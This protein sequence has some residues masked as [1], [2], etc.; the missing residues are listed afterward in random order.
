ML[1]LTG[2]P[3]KTGE[4][5]W[6]LI[7]RWTLRIKNGAFGYPIFAMPINET[8]RDEKGRDA[9]SHWWLALITH[10]ARAGGPQKPIK[11]RVTLE[12]TVRDKEDDPCFIACIDSMKRRTQF[13][14]EE[15]GMKVFW[16]GTLMK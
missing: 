4:E 3:A 12:G 14:T 15:D 13:F 9:G 6:E 5:A 8:F 16:E 11:E 1:S 2:S 10:A 7:K